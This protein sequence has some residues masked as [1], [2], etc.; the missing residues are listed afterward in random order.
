MDYSY[1]TSSS[2]SSL[3]LPSPDEFLRGSRRVI[4]GG[5]RLLAGE[6][7]ELVN[8][9]QAGPNFS[10]LVEALNREA[11]RF[12]YR[13]ENNMERGLGKKRREQIALNMKICEIRDQCKEMWRKIDLAKAAAKTQIILNVQLQREIDIKQE[14]INE[15]AGQLEKVER[16]RKREVRKREYRNWKEYHNQRREMRRLRWEREQ[17]EK[18]LKEAQD[19]TFGQMVR[20]TYQKV[21][22][23]MD[24]ANVWGWLDSQLE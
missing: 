17:I 1:Y 12:L 21:A 11:I 18:E 9:S 13:L 20:R 16:D 10:R 22:E 2:G 7:P 6:I 15:K 8:D 23:W 19:N 14:L 24:M 4:D 3:D 5:R